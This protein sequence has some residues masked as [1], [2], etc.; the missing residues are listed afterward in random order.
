MEQEKAKVLLQRVQASIEMLT[1]IKKDLEEFLGV[2]EETPTLQVSETYLGDDGKEYPPS[3]PYIKAKQ[4]YCCG[5][6]LVEK[7]VDGK[8]VFHCE[9]CNSNYMA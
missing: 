1:N 4:W 5:K 9:K 6:P 2:E 7:V 3:N 8:K